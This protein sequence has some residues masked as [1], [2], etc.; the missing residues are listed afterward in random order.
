MKKNFKK[1]KFVILPALA[2]LVLTSVA[3]VTGTAAWFTVNRAVTVTGMSFIAK[4]ESNLLIAAD[5]LANGNQLNDSAF[6]STLNQSIN[7]TLKPASTVNARNFF[8]TE[9]AKADGSSEKVEYNDVSANTDNAYFKEYVFQL[10]AINVETSAQNIYV[11]ELDIKYGTNYATGNLANAVKAFRAA[12]FIEKATNSNFVLGTATDTGEKQISV[13]SIYTP[14]GADNQK[15]GQAVSSANT[16]TAVEYVNDK[17]NLILVD[18]NTSSYFKV[19]CR[20]WLEGEDKGCTDDLFKS[21]KDSWNFSLGLRLGS[22]EEMNGTD[23]ATGKKE[24]VEHIK[25]SEN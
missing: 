5:T 20:V 4:S 8:A 14:S 16:T 12:F 13:K 9:K 25:V 23:M 24:A 10:K 19:V 15:T 22:T 11:D 3:T 1:S 18:A 21:A 17:K 2:T 6:G 7:G